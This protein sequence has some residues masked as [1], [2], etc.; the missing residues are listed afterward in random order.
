MYDI[1]A[2]SGAGSDAAVHTCSQNR[3]YQIFYF[4][5]NTTTQGLGVMHEEAIHIRGQKTV[6]FHLQT[7][8]IKGHGPWFNPR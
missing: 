1:K 2:R 7:E 6:R 8:I 5:L 3:W 4:H